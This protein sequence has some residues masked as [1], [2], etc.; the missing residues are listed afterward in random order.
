MGATTVA[1]T[2]VRDDPY[3]LASPLDAIGAHWGLA[4]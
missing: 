3:L 2:F 4:A 1:T